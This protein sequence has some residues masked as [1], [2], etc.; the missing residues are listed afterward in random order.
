MTRPLGPAQI[1]YTISSEN[2]R[3]KAQKR[4]QGRSTLVLLLSVSLRQLAATGSL[5]GT[6]SSRAVGSGGVAVALVV[7]HMRRIWDTEAKNQ[8]GVTRSKREY[9]T[10]SPGTA[11]HQGF[12]LLLAMI[13]HG[14]HRHRQASTN[15]SDARFWAFHGVPRRKSSQDYRP[16]GC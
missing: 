7:G 15:A 3:W 10:L 6:P 2:A 12:K 5:H 14:S 4:P 11:W 9:C 13:L 8:E 1:M 16:V